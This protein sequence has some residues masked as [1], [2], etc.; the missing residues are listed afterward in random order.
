MDITDLDMPKKGRKRGLD[1]KTKGAELKKKARSEET[2]EER[3]ARLAYG[4]KHDEDRRR[5]ETKE[6]QSSRKDYKKER[7]A[8]L[9]SQ[10]TY[11]QKALR[12][13]EQRERQASNRKELGQALKNKKKL[14]C[15]QDIDHFD[16]NE[17][18]KNLKEHDIKSLYHEDNKV[19]RHCGAYRWKDERPGFCCEN[20][21]VSLP[22]IKLLPEEIKDLFEQKELLDNIR[23][24]NNALALSSIGCDEKYVPGFNPTF[25][26]QG[27]VFHRIGSLKPSEGE[28]P[29]FAQLYFYDSDNEVKNRLHHNPHLKEDILLRLQDCLKR[30]NPYIESLQYATNFCEENPELKVVIHPDRKPRQEHPRKY[31]LPTGS[32]IAIIMPGE[33]EGP[34]DVILQNKDGKLQSINSLH[35][36][37]DPLHYVLL[38]PGGDD[39][40][41]DSI[42]KK[43]GKGSDEKIK[44]KPGKEST[45]KTKEK[46]GKES[47]EKTKEKR[48]SP[49]EFYKYRL[50]VRKDDENTIMKGR[51]LTQQYATDGYAKAELQRLQWVRSHQK[52]IRADKYKGL[53]DAVNENDGVNAGQK[54]ILPPTV[55]GSPRWYAESFQNAMA[56]VRKHGK[57]D[58]F[59]TFTTNPQ[60]PEIQSSL[61]PGES[62]HDRPDICDRVFKIKHTDLLHNTLLKYQALGKVKAYTSMIEFQ[63]RGLPHSHIL[64]ILDDEDK[65]RTPEAINRIVS[66]EIPD[67]SVNPSLHAIVTKHMVHGPCGVANPACACMETT[68]DGKVCGKEFPKEFKEKTS[69]NANGYPFYRRRSPENGGRTHN[70]SVKG[71]D[72]TVDNRWI[73][74]Y[75]PFLSLKY[76]AHLNV[77]VVTSVQCVKYLY[78]YITKGSDRVIIQLAN[79]E[80]KDIS[81]DEVERFNNAR[82]IS[83][84][85]A[86]WR[87][88]EFRIAEMYPSVEK[89]PLHLENEQRVYFQ[90]EQA[91]EIASQPPPKT[92]LTAYFELN[93]ENPEA[94]HI[95]Y[96]DIFQH[97]TWKDDHWVKR[98][99]RRS[100]I[101][102]DGEALS[103]TIGRIPVIGLNANQTELYYMR[104]LLYHKAGAK[105]FGD[106]R[107]VDGVEYATFQEA[108]LKL[109]LLDDDAENDRA[110][111]EAASI[112]FGP[113]LR[114]MFAMILVWNRPIEPKEFWERHRNILSEDFLRRDRV[115]EPNEEI[116]NEVLLEIEEHVQRNGFEME[117]FQLPKPD[118]RLMKKRVP[119]E[120]REE[121]EY[122]LD[123]LKEIVRENVPLL[124]KEQLD[125]Y[126]AILDSVKKGNG[127]MFALDAPGGSG[128]TFL[129][130]TILATIRAEGEIALAT[131]TSGIAA[132]L[133]PN[134]RTLHSRCKVPVEGLDENSFCNVTKRD[135]TAELIRRAVFLV[136]DEVTMAKKEVYEAVNRTFQ[137]IRG[138]TLPFGGVTVLFSGDWRQILPVVRHGGRADI[139]EA[140]FKSSKL[141]QHIANY[142]IDNKQSMYLYVS[143]SV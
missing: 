100:K 55:T 90:S 78:K 109:G 99:Y 140:C 6:E 105:S 143:V 19:C 14:G 40:Y 18:P 95:L 23:S 74:P 104:M 142:K 107:T 48:V 83:A 79:G 108:C 12:L 37:Y 92:K 69:I 71:Q 98:C 68:A 119:R 32:E 9:R 26:I 42:P 117:T 96:P 21:R 89:L 103:D 15:F 116:L 50:Q 52:E 81:N 60:W 114:E 29:K 132:T 38:F 115:D 101:D 49:V 10:E 84:S 41:T 94:R 97:Y 134:G 25:K 77:E 128:K 67:A 47:T 24:Y 4:R 111:E 87:L 53:L 34:L 131:A 124:N 76:N 133:L 118:P 7:I 1:H 93:K 61:L 138:N 28:V 91:S 3:S 65:P 2:Q 110:I 22:P 39:G 59:I 57:P 5:N 139:I 130:S 73:V 129:T 121:T 85:Q 58:V 54:V 112:R 127:G 27:K 62:P 125:V 135:A 63:K 13:V 31:N 20:G 56:L 45:E 86:Y 36:S 106:L 75:N 44:E 136:V 102:R 46:P 80:M 17:Y 123:R 141:W 33:Q 72:F 8:Y 51:R 126:N 88:Y 43:P 120:L 11:G 16:E 70:T 137:D 82:Y 64:L 30:V 122:D 35:R 113:Q 66:A